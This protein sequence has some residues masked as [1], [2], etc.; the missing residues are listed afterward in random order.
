MKKILMD[1]PYF[2]STASKN[3]VQEIKTFNF[4]N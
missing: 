2:T 3:K 4:K 1:Q